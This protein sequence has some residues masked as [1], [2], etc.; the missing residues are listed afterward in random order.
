MGENGAGST[1]AIWAVCVGISATGVA[2]DLL[3]RILPLA[4]N[5]EALSPRS[6]RTRLAQT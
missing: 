2:I 5:L 1:L 3:G 6:W 4:V